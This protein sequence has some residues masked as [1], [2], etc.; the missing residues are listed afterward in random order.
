MNEYF[1]KFIISFCVFG[2][3]FSFVRPQTTYAVTG[4]D[5]VIVVGGVVV[6]SEMIATL[7]GGTLICGGAA[8]YANTDS[9]D[10][11]YL[12]DGLIKTGEGAKYIATQI[13][14]AGKEFLT[15]TSDGIKYISDSIAGMQSIGYFNTGSSSI[16]LPSTIGP[17]GTT[18]S[19]GYL[20][21]S[22]SVQVVYGAG[23]SKLIPNNVEL[24]FNAW[25]TSTVVLDYR[26]INTGKT[27]GTA[28]TSNPISLSVPISFKISDGV[29]SFSSQTATGVIGSSS[30]SNDGSIC[31][32]PSIGVPLTNTG[33]VDA[34]TGAKVYTPDVSIPYGKTLPDIQ[35]DLG[36]TYPTVTDTPIDVPVDT[37]GTIDASTGVLSI[38]ILGDILKAL[39]D[40]LQ[41]LKDMIGNFVSALTKMITDIF[42]PTDT[43]FN[44]EFNKL[45][46]PVVAKFP[47]NL[48]ILNSLKTDGFSFSD[49]KITIMGVTGVI[50]SA[51]FVNDNISLIRALTSC[52]WVFL[53]IMYVWRKINQ[54]LTGNEV[55]QP[56]VRDKGGI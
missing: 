32:Q 34:N 45:K 46:A 37:T 39:L 5:D 27:L 24:V 13:D 48:D 10:L 3:I 7:I 25:S 16:T 41:F 1:K 4:V 49:I 2:F 52:F 55:I 38:P 21:G 47:H 36:I 54:F 42:V 29:K 30:T 26:D 18:V 8:I 53:L 31:Y 22:A 23:Y 40:I 17:A 35:K 43:F 50:V 28:A 12:A 15:W 33:S 14:N 20:T 44:D 9:S 19:A 6:T 11:K 51:K 56:A